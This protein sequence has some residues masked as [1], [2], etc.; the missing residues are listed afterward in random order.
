MVIS[1]GG[2]VVPCLM[3]IFMLVS[4]LIET[5][6]SRHQEPNKRQSVISPSGKYVLTVPIERSKVDRGPLGFGEP[7]WYVT[8]SDPNGNIIYRDPEEDFPGRFGT[9][10]I[11]DEK[12]RVWIFGSDSGICYYEHADGT[13]TR[14]GWGESNNDD[15]EPPESLYPGSFKRDTLEEYDL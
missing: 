13:W 9:Y 15:I 14:H 10:W 11:W 12:D 8:I 5:D 6:E 1:L 3:L 2:T 4:S 7:Y